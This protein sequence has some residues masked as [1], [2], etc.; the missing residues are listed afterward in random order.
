MPHPGNMIWNYLFLSLGL[1]ISET[2]R[3]KNTAAHRPPAAAVKPPVKM[4]SSPSFATASRYGGA[5]PG[6]VDERLIKT[7]RPQQHACHHVACEYAGGGELRAVYEHLTHHAQ[8][9]AHGKG[10]QVLKQS[11]H[12]YTSFSRLTAWLMPGMEQ[13]C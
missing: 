7:Q 2:S 6:P 12:P 8:Q 5:S 3:E 13:P 11:I 4:P 1:N 10:L 9:P